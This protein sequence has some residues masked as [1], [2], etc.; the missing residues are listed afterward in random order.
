MPP[1]AA[2]QVQA[3]MSSDLGAVKAI[4]RQVLFKTAP[5]ARS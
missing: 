1:L 3:A 5:G 4:F 2:A